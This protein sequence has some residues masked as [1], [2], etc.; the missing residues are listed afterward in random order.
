MG[1][2]RVKRQRSEVSLLSHTQTSLDIIELSLIRW[3]NT[4][5]LSPFPS[6]A[7]SASQTHT[8]ST[9]QVRTISPEESRHLPA[10]KEEPS[11]LRRSRHL[12]PGKGRRE[13]PDRAAEPPTKTKTP[14]TTNDQ[15]ELG[16]RGH[17]HYGNDLQMLHNSHR[18]AL[19]PSCTKSLMF[20][21]RTG[22][23]SKHSHDGWGR[24]EGDRKSAMTCFCGISTITTPSSLA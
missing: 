22:V 16:L 8:L 4:L 24:Q 15:A 6:T 11:H 14:N 5:T 19:Q 9:A 17:H 7:V 20:V 3:I 13:T 12:P 1:V 2:G 21:S 18:Y 10:G 23:E